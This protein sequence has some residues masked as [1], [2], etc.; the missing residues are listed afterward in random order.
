MSIQHRK[1]T[2]KWSWYYAHCTTLHP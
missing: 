2:T 1:I